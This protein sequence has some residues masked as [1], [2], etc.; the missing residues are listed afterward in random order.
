MGELGQRDFSQGWRPDD[1]A[2]NGHANGLLRADNCTLD[3][4]GVLGIVRGIA[5]VSPNM[6]SQN[7]RL[8]SRL[9]NGAKHRYTALGSGTVKKDINEAGTF[10]TTVLTGGVA[11]RTGFGLSLGQVLITSG[12]VKKKDDG[13][14][15]SDLGVETPATKPTVGA[16]TRTQ[17]G[18]LSGPAWSIIEG[19]GS[20]PL[21][22]VTDATTGRARVKAIG[23]VFTPTAAV[24]ENDV[25][26]FYLTP[27][28]SSTIKLYRVELYLKSSAGDAS[29]TGEYYY[30]EWKVADG[31]S[32]FNTGLGLYN[33]I[34]LKRKDFIRYGVDYSLGWNNVETIVITFEG[35]VSEAVN[36]HA[37]GTRVLAGNLNGS[38]TY[39]QVNVY[40]NGKYL[41]KSPVGPISDVVIALDQNINVTPITPAAWA[42]PIDEM[43]IYRRKEGFNGTDTWYRVAVRTATGLFIDSVKD[44]DALNT[45]IRVNLNVAALPDHIIDIVGNYGDRVLYLT[46]QQLYISDSRN[47][48]AIDSRGTLDFSGEGSETNLWIRKADANSILVGTTEDIYEVQGTLELLG[49]GTI[50]ARIIPL[51]IGDPPIAYDAA[52]FNHQVIYMARDGWRVTVGANTQSILGNTRLLY[53]GVSRH[54][55]PVVIMNIEREYQYPCA[56]SFGKLYCHIPMSDTIPGRLLHYD[57][58]NRYWGQT[59]TAPQSLFTEEDGTLLAGYDDFVRKINTS[60]GIDGVAGWDVL[61]RTPFLD[62]GLQDQRKDLYVLHL[63]MDTGN[64]NCIIKIAGNGGALTTL[65][66]KAFDGPEHITIDINSHAVNLSKTIQMEFSGTFDVFKLYHWFI[67]FEERPKPLNFLRL[68]P[69]NYGIP[70]KKRIRTIPFV[71]D[72]LG[73]DVTVTP[74]VDG[75]NG[76]TSTQ[77]TSEKRTAFH[78]FVTDIFG[79]DY[80]YRLQCTGD[81]VFEFYDAPQPAHVEVL[82]IAKKFDQVGPWETEKLGK[83]REIR[84]RLIAGTTSIG[85]ELFADDASVIS[86]T[87]TTVVNV[88]KV[89][90][91]PMTKTI[92]GTVW[93]LELLDTVEFHRH[94][95]KFRY[96]LSGDETSLKQKYIE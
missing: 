95:V 38:Y 46:R 93:R 76:T 32:P 62:A 55:E 70:A 1:D 73:N 88:D 34:S 80:E 15:I 20:A 89:Y 87:L 77:N 42:A 60:T 90:T 12:T 8:F 63:F 57:F 85:W 48:D 40:N 74:R 79:I 61:V 44:Q 84:V 10:G 45:G 54:G 11:D 94:W 51:G 91:I 4:K 9:L 50:D 22:V 58:E 30:S 2:V 75:V 28:D 59:T 39:Y 7:K 26:T 23:S 65:D 29:G 16:S 72:T 67:T 68:R 14:T 19:S 78:Y 53:A 81:E 47:P 52:V 66:T 71:I 41:A 13:T 3:E 43:W 37:S 6:G 83:M 25:L 17:V 27:A 82:P 35:G 31:N 5:K 92:K 24:N 56:V 21:S 49:D 64:V 36:F 33:A 86:G 18:F 96:A 69:T